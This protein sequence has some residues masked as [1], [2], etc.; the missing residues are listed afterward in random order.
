MMEAL[1]KE[2]IKKAL[3]AQQVLHKDVYWFMPPA[4]G[5]GISGIFDFVVAVRGCLIGIESKRDAKTKPTALQVRNGHR[6]IAAGCVVLFVHADN[7]ELVEDVIEKVRA[8]RSAEGL[9]E[10]NHWPF[11]PVDV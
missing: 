5:Y 9:A 8:A 4:N 11:D 3:A 2:R 10:L 6:A 7:T 1:V